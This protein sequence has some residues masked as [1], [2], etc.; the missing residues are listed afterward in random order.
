[1]DAHP[2]I[3]TSRF[4]IQA[5]SSCRVTILARRTARPPHFCPVSVRC[6]SW[7]F[8][9]SFVRFRS[10]PGYGLA[11]YSCYNEHE[12]VD[13]HGFPGYAP[14]RNTEQAKYRASLD[15]LLTAHKTA[16]YQALGHPA[17]QPR[18]GLL[19]PE[20]AFDFFASTHHQAAVIAQPGPVAKAKEQQS[21]N[22]EQQ[23][24]IE[25][26]SISWI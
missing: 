3:R 22:E 7:P 4:R 16:E 6:I 18:L 17:F 19:Y 14:R 13:A 12:R 10:L 2:W 8:L 26:H 9:T 24:M 11:G 5:R 23:S 20:A 25:E 21:T 15:P 1:M